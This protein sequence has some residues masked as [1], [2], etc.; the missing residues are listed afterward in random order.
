VETCY[1]SGKEE[2]ESPLQEGRTRKIWKHEFLESVFR[3]AVWKE[4]D[5]PVNT[6]DTPR[7]DVGPM[8]L[9]LLFCRVTSQC[10]W[11]SREDIN[12]AITRTKIPFIIVL[13][14]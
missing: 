7:K 14:E 9:A 5:S 3:N 2:I 6:S 13:A 11:E 12:F 4:G 1:W 10:H 8:F